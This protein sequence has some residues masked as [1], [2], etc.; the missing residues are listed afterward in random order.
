LL[1]EG[2]VAAFRVHT[3]TADDCPA[4]PL[5]VAV[6]ME[7]T[8]ASDRSRPH[9]ARFGSLVHETLASV[10]L[11]A[12]QAEV[13]AAAHAHG[14]I[15]G[16][17]EAEVIAAAEAVTAALAHPVLSAARAAGDA[18]RREAP[19]LFRAADGALIEGVVDLAYRDPGGASWVVVD[20]K[21]DVDG[22]PRRASYEKQVALYAA[23]V[24]G[25]TGMPARAVLLHV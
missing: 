17:P 8:G 5:S 11:I 4:P 15:L 24:A 13:L 10:S 3:V 14:H 20:Y 18:C 21:T 7:T 9:G 16:A 19:V 6:S 23:A 25:A 12:G 2:A 1:E 22:A